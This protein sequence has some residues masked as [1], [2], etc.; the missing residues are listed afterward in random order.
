MPSAF[1][2]IPLPDATVSSGGTMTSPTWDVSDAYTVGVKVTTAS[3][4]PGLTAVATL[5]SSDTTFTQVAYWQSTAQTL[6]QT[7]S[8]QITM[9]EVGPLFRL[10]FQTSAASTG[11]IIVRGTKYVQ[12]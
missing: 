3:T 4:A 6:V 2:A 11:G 10:A 1:L 5:N 12:V 9:F 8:G 7:S